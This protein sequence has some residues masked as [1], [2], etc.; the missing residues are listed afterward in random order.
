[1]FVYVCLCSFSVSNLRIV[2]LGKNGSDNNSVGNIILGTEAFH[3]EDSSYSHLSEIISGKVEKTHITVINSHLL[4]P[5]FPQH[6][7]IKAVCECVS[8]SAPGPHVFVLVLQYNDFTENDRQRV[9]YVLNL[10]SEQAIKHTIVVTTDEDTFASKITSKIW[11]NVV[12]NLIKEC[13]GHLKFDTRNSGFRSE[14]LKKTEE[15]L[16]KERKEHLI[17]NKYEDGGGTPVDED[18]NRYGASVKGNGKEEE[19][20]VESTKTGCDGGVMTTGKAKLNIVLCGSNSA[21]K[22]SVSKLFRG[23]TKPGRKEIS[24]VCQKRDGTINGRQINVIELPA[25]T[26]LSEEEVMRQTLCCLSLCDPGVHHFILV[27]PVSPLANED[28]AEMEKIKRIFYSKE[29]FMLLFITELTVDKSVSDFI[30]SSES[31]SVVSLYGSCYSVMGLKD[32]RSSQQISDLFSY[33][34]S[35]KTEPYSL[36]MYLRAPEKRVRHELEE[37]LRVKDNEIK[38]LQKKIKTLDGRELEVYEKE[39]L[40][41]SYLTTWIDNILITCFKEGLDDEICQLVLW[42]H[43]RMME[44]L[45]SPLPLPLPVQVSL[46]TSL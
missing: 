6:Q 21:L 42:L 1:M 7:S 3:R 12:S 2:L 26:Q 16:K 9:K 39:F 22:N 29:H 43:Q 4:Q 10:F 20:S 44:M 35:M 36:Q 41:Y 24:K 37:K 38:E 34:E 13:G 14:M 32:Q 25:L 19:N 40:E 11:N 27:T 30:K 33:I 45:F 17:C 18:Q 23:I 46:V 15:T 8:L 28:K 31:Q 5:N